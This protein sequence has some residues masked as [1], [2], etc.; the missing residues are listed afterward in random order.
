MQDVLELQ[1][2]IDEHAFR[3]AWEQVAQL[4]AALRTRIVQQSELGLLQV[5]VKEKMQWTE[6]KSME[7]YLNEDKAASMGLGDRLARYALV[8]ESCGGKRWFVWTIH[9]ALYD[10]WS[11]PLV[12][13][14]VKQVYS[15]AALERQPSFN[16]FIQYVSQQ[17]VKAAAA[18]WQTALAD[19]E[20][21]LFPPLPLTIS[22]PVADTTVE[23]QCPPL[24]QSATDITM[25]TSIRAAWAMVASRYTSSDDIVFG[26][27]VTGRNAPIG[28]VE[29]M[30]GPTIATVP[31]RVRPRKDQTVSAFLGNLQQQATEMIAYEQ[32]GLQR[33]MKMGPGPQ[34]A[35]GFQTLLVVHPTD[36]VLSSD[37]TLGEWHSRSDSELQYFTTYA[38]TI[39]CTLAVEG[40]QITASFDARVVEHWPRQV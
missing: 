17:D 23:Y 22:Q 24:P 36:D 8:K 37:D 14:A 20:A 38:L 7:E 10:G 32:T 6:S 1:A 12:L 4:T 15:G 13:D 19:C 30:V 31:L 21:V 33:I 16:T 18:Y 35:C 2:D 40:V 9:H 34:H 11:L 25:S 26:T 39:Q 28:G 3:A 5:V 27:T 29:T